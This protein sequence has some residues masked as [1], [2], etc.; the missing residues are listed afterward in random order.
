MEGLGLGGCHELDCDTVWIF[1]LKRVVAGAAS[2]RILLRIEA[3]EPCQGYPVGDCV[4]VSARLCVK[5][6]M[7]QSYA[8]PMVARLEMFFW[9]LDETQVG[10]PVQVADAFRPAL[11]LVISKF[12]KKRL[13]ELKRSL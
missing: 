10:F 11:R 3:C 4:N 8:L 6:E 2:I 7:V 1:A 12:R 13:P 5:R 9:S